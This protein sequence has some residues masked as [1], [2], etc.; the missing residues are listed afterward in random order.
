MAARAARMSFSRSK[1]CVNSTRS[2]LC[3]RFFPSVSTARHFA[4]TSLMC[5]PVTQ[6]PKS[7][8][9]MSTSTVAPPCASWM[10]MLTPAYGATFDE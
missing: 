10:M 4:T 6:A 7:S 8:R 9:L 1:T 2:V 3:S 5:R